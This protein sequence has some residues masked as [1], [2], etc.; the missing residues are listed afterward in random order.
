MRAEQLY[1]HSLGASWDALKAAA[2][3]RLRDSPH[4]SDFVEGGAEYSVGLAALHVLASDPNSDLPF[5]LYR[6]QS[7][8][9]VGS[10]HQW[11]SWPMWQDAFQATFKRSVA[12]FYEE[13]NEGYDGSPD[14][15]IESPS[16]PFIGG[17]VH[18]QG[19]APTLTWAAQPYCKKQNG[20]VDTFLPQPGRS[21]G[22]FLFDVAGYAECKLRVSIDSLG[23]A[24]YVAHGQLVAE[25]KNAERFRIDETSRH[26]VLLRLDDGSCSARFAGRLSTISGEPLA[27]VILRASEPG[28]A[29]VG[30]G[31]LRPASSV[32][33]GP[34]GSFVFSGPD[35]SRRFIQARLQLGSCSRYISNGGDVLPYRQDVWLG[36]HGEFITAVVPHDACGVAFLRG[37]VRDPS[38]RPHPGALIT[39][40]AHSGGSNSA[41]ADPRGQF[42]IGVPTAGNYRVIALVRQRNSSC[43][44]L[45]ESDLMDGPESET[46]VFARAGVT[47][48][49]EI[50]IPSSC[51]KLVGTLSGNIE[52]LPAGLRLRAIRDDGLESLYYEIGRDG[53]FTVD[54]PHRGSYRLLLELNGGTCYYR[55]PSATGLASEAQLLSVG[56]GEVREGLNF[57]IPSYGC[58]LRLAGRLLGANGVA[59]QGALVTAVHVQD[60]SLAGSSTGQEGYFEITVPEPG[61][62]RLRASINGCM[63]YYSTRGAIGSSFEATQ[64]AVSES[65]NTSLRMQVG[66]STCRRSISGRLVNADGSPRANELVSAGSF[67]GGGSWAETDLNGAFTL[68]VPEAGTY[69]LLTRVDDCSVFHRA[70]GATSDATEATRIDVSTSDIQ[71]I[72]FRVPESLPG[73]CD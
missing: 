14:S 21:G 55:E 8:N 52:P 6:A 50:N 48:W 11:L 72:E 26:D 7:P 69:L 33:T 47:P 1:L 32:R 63:V 41:S 66:N 22:S 64:I 9:T 29:F 28:P 13:F 54:I 10:R 49:L 58:G 37:V 65:G 53:S 3:H 57:R 51:S 34:D 23:C 62:Y 25:A 19:E 70:G 43:S 42:A 73:F 56:P 20:D 71:D 40:R 67:V 45:Y 24:G 44:V 30:G 31:R 17:R 2:R 36:Y 39:A 59:V 61:V 5:E 68:S 27:G 60:G 46:A 15:S 35:S 16:R 18:L 38:G 12:D 4:I